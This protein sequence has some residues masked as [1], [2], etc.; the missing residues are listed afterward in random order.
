MIIEVKNKEQIDQVAQL[1]DEIWREHYIP[2]I[3][4]KQVDYMLSKFQSSQA[5]SHQI[6]EE[7]YIYYLIS[8]GN[9]N[10]GYISVKEKDKELFVS[11]VYIHSDYRGKGFGRQAINF[12]QNKANELKL[13]RI[14][15]TVNKNNTN[16]IKVYEKLGFKN[17]GSI[18]QDIGKGFVMDDYKME[19]VIQSNNN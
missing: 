15:L 11:K 3:G 1:A 7:G 14:T 8:E 9:K 6:S 18:I 13:D 10:L 12:I 17:R 5:I 19:M 16:S 2:I 4:I